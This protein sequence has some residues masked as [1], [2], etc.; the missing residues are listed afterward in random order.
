MLDHALPRLGVYG[1]RQAPVLLHNLAARLASRPLQRYVPQRQAL[2]I[3]DVGQGK[4]LA[5]R[6]RFWWA[7]RLSL[8]W[9]S[10]LDRG[11]LRQ[12]RR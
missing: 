10:R 2:A 7:G 4:G 12:F 8:A 6:G 9:K 3:L 5:I 1:V 11:F